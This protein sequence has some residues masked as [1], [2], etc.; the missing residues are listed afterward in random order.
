VA[1]LFNEKN[2][3]ADGLFKQ[4]MLNYSLRV[5]E[6]FLPSTLEFFEIINASYML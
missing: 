6:V 3:R 2:M 5:E 1:H 4:L